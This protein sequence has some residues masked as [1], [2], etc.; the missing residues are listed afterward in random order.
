MSASLI[1]T[2]NAAFEQRNELSPKNS[3]ADIRNAVEEAI[4]QLD[5]GA[6]R[7]AQKVDGHW[8]V[9]EWLKKAVLLSFRLNDNQPR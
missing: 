7:V 1:D 8:Q 2:I 4:A 3:P 6:A 5:S 9:N